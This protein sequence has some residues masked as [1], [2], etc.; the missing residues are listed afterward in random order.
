MDGKTRQQMLEEVLQ[1]FCRVKILNYDVL[2]DL[3]SQMQN[4]TNSKGDEESSLLFIVRLAKKEL[5]K[6]KKAVTQSDQTKILRSVLQDVVNDLSIHLRIY[7]PE[8]VST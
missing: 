2:M 5:K 8:Q 4:I 1:R 6:Y 7:F 3:L